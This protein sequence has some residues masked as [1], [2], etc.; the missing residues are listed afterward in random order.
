MGSNWRWRFQWFFKSSNRDPNW[1]WRADSFRHSSQIDGAAWAAHA[2]FYTEVLIGSDGS[3][4]KWR[5]PTFMLLAITFLID[6][7][8]F[9]WFWAVFLLELTLEICFFINH[10]LNGNWED[11]SGGS[12]A[13]N[14]IRKM[15]QAGATKRINNAS[16]PFEN[17]TKSYKLY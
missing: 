2:D 4:W 9:H 8:V 11:V 13:L 5:F 1:R 16:K 14:Q 17:S 6:F 10:A 12:S 7:I 3:N 15:P